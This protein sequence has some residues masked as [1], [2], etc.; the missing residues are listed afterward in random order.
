MASPAPPEAQPF[1]FLDLPVEIRFM[2]YSQLAVRCVD[3][4]VPGVDLPGCVVDASYVGYCFYPA[5]LRVSQEFKIEY[6]DY[7]LPRMIL[8]A[9]WLPCASHG[10]HRRETLA[11]PGWPG[12]LTLPKKVIARLLYFC[13]V[14]DTPLS[15]PHCSKPSQTLS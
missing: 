2:I 12:C 14:I 3:V 5:M 7:A 9:Y 11:R 4:R 15:T 13:M 8:F 10:P 1:R 6:S